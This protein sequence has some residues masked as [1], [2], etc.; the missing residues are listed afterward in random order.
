VHRLRQPT[1]PRSLAAWRGRRADATRA[2]GLKLLAGR[3]APLAPVEPSPVERQ[4]Q[5]IAR[6]G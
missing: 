5:L 2:E 6:S 4:Q 1:Q 3:I